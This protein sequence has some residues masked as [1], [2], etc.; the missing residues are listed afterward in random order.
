MVHRQLIQKKGNVHDHGP[1][2][3]GFVTQIV[4]KKQI[5]R[6]LK[7]TIF[8]H[9]ILYLYS[10]FENVHLQELAFKKLKNVVESG[11]IKLYVTCE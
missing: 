5:Y 4:S 7:L 6:F 11:G 9:K 2:I 1:E 8:M 10:A 3:G